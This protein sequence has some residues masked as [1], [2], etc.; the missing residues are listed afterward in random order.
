MKT[1]F[2]A[3]ALFALSSTAMADTYVKGYTRSNG[4]YV[5]P[6]YRSSPDSNPNNN[7]SVQGNVNPHTGQEG[8]RPPQYA[9]PPSYSPPQPYQ[10]SNP[11]DNN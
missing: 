6:H 1:T 5:E 9:P 3:I 8:T 10:L 2:I 4:T 7:W 11:Y